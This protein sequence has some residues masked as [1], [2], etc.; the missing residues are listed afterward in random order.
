MQNQKVY[1]K[2]WN[3]GVIP[4]HRRRL[5]GLAVLAGVPQGSILGPLLFLIF[6]NDIVENINCIIRLFADDTSLILPSID[7]NTDLH[8]L[9]SDLDKLLK[10]AKDW[11]V[12]FNSTKTKTLLISRRTTQT[13]I[14]LKFE[15]TALQLST[16]HKHLGITLNE[17]A[18]W[19]NHIDEI[20]CKA[21]KRLGILRNLKYSLN[22]D[23][24]HLLYTT[25]IKS[26]LEYAD[27][28]W[29][30][31]P[32]HLSNR[33]EAINKNAIRCI[34]GLTV[35]ARSENLYNESG[36]LPLAKRR[37][38]HRLVQMYKITH[39]L[40]PNY[41]RDLLPPSTAERNPYIVRD[42]NQLTNFLCITESFRNSYLPCTIREWNSLPN[43]IR[44][45]PSVESFKYQLKQIDE[46]N[47]RR[48]PAWYAYGPRHLNI[49]LTRMRNNCS[50]LAQDLYS[51][52][53]RIAPRCGNC[54][55]DRA[56]DANHFFLE[57][58]KFATARLQMS[59][60]FANL[61]ISLATEFILKGSTQHNFEF[62][63]RILDPVLK[64]LSE[65][66]RS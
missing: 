56:E 25:Y 18:T 8:I 51:N 52:H 11:S 59:E 7:L 17:T 43:D 10:W 58:P 3:T 22:R 29:D 45:S 36:L 33:I 55:M 50:A 66:K 31:I 23:S 14:E 64:Y 1:A 16:D 40:S 39:D 42:R 62:N 44:T 48:P 30:N 28:V 57:C 32:Q 41:L 27:T 63:K 61:N 5:F 12:N 21:N 15:N 54:N 35:S 9:Q 53:I 34:T 47:L 19:T 46:F 4:N 26:L 38:F 24:L 60:T 37:K 65:T 20:V 2:I 49:N 6:I 13:D